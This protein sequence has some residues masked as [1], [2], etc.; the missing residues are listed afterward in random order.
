M[1]LNFSDF[2]TVNQLNTQLGIL[3]A[4]F[5]QLFDSN[6]RRRSS[7]TSFSPSDRFEIPSSP[8][9]SASRAA[10]HKFG[11][12]DQ[13]REAE[14]RRSEDED[15]EIQRLAMD[16]LMDQKL[17]ANGANTPS[18]L[19]RQQEELLT[20]L[21]SIGEAADPRWLPVYASSAGPG[22]VVSVDG[23]DS[24]DHDEPHSTLWY[25]QDYWRRKY[26]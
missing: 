1:P 14:A 10:G 4:Q 9:A 23:D 2:S 19:Q 5:Q 15:A 7:A 20:T 16:A 18:A 17:A 12:D 25:Q 24:G 13:R 21:E 22:A 26:Q 3:H 11:K 6:E 8:T